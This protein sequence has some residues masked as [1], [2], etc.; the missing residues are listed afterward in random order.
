M[1]V[2]QSLTQVHIIG[3]QWIRRR[4][5]PA[6]EREKEGRALNAIANLTFIW[7]TAVRWRTAGSVS[8]SG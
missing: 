1:T 8:G 7:F 4:L 3:R 5:A 2:V 6:T